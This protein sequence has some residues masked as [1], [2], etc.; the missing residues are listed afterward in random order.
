M[1][2]IEPA[3]AKEFAQDWLEAWNQRDIE[4]VLSHYTEDFEMSS[5]FIVQI[6]GESSGTLKGKEKIRAYWTKALERVPNLHLELLS[7][8]I[9]TQSITLYYRGVGGKL[10]AEVFHFGPDKKITK[11]FAHYES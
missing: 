6:M 8:L 11:A 3:F 9:G 5:P 7:T 1:N 2:K 4:R 10:S